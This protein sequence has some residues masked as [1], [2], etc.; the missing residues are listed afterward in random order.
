M[1]NTLERDGEGGTRLGSQDISCARY[2]VY[3]VTQ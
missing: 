3:V 2:C 1:S